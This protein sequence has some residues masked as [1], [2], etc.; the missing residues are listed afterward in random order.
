MTWSDF[1]LGKAEE[2]DRRGDE[3]ED[4]DARAEWFQMARDWRVAA[5]QPEPPDGREK[6]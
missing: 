5:T 6:P 4:R 2:C 3:M 1:C